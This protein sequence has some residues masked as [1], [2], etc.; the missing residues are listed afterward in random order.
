MPHKTYWE[1]KGM[2]IDWSGVIDSTE[3]LKSNGAIY[4]DKRFDEIRY[5]INDF[6]K[7]EFAN[8]SDKEIQIIATLELQASDWNKHMKVVHVTTDPN[9]IADIRIYEKRMEASGWQ[10]LI[11]DTLDEARK[12]VEV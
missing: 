10:F 6:L 3:V 12:W 7:A 9:L 11:C 4:G 1:E 5:Q 8:F 2:L